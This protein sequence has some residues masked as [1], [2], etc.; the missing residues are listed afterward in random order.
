MFS[1]NYQTAWTPKQC[2]SHKADPQ[3]IDNVCVQFHVLKHKLVLIVIRGARKY[4]KKGIWFS[5][6]CT[7]HLRNKIWACHFQISRGCFWWEHVDHGVITIRTASS[8]NCLIVF[9]G[10]HKYYKVVCYVYMFSWLFSSPEK[11]HG[12][13]M[14]RAPPYRIY[15]RPSIL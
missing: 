3:T 11:L 12:T 6:Q 15:G 14:P 13:C 1:N 7:Q 10:A 4:Y 2:H 5:D 8:W 9:M